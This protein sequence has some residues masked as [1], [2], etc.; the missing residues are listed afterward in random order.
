MK[1]LSQQGLLNTDKIDDILSQSKPNQI[2]KIKFNENRI[3]SV[4]PK[5]IAE[6][7]IEDF[8]VKS[9]EFYSKHLMQ[10]EI[11]NKLER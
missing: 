6:D 7:K 8:V 5:Y 4:L 10:K 3:K 1:K 9:I 2:P 11:K